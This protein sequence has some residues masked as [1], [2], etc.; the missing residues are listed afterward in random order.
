MTWYNP[1]AFVPMAVTLVTCLVYLAIIIPLLIVHETVPSAPENPTIYRGL[2]LTEAWLDLA[3]LSNGY[4][5]YNSHRNDEVRNWLLRRVEA[6]LDSNGVNYETGPD[7]SGIKAEPSHTKE[8]LHGSEYEASVFELGLGAQSA[9]SD[10]LRSRSTKPAAVVFNDLASNYTTSALTSIGVTGRRLGISTYFEGNNI[11]VYIRGTEDEEED[12]WK[13]LPPYTHRLH[14]K[15][16]VMVNAHFDSVSTGYG[17]TDDGMGVVTAL[18]LIKYYTTEGNTP[19]RGV[20]VLLNNGEED[21]LYGAKAFLSHPMATFVHTFLNLEGAGAGGR[22]MLFRSTDTEVTRAYGSAKHPLGTVVSAD[23]FALGFIR[24]ETD[25]VVFRAEGY[26]GLDV[27]F[28]EPRARYHTEQDDAKH[29]SRDSLW[30]MLSASVATMDYLTSHTEEFVGPRRDNLPGK[31]KNGRG[32]DG[33]WFDLFGMVMAVFGLRKLFAWSLTILIASPLILMLVSYLLIRQDKYYL[34]SGAVK[35]EGRETEVVSLKGWRGAFRFP[36][37]LIISGALTLG[38]AFLLKKIN[39]LIVYSSPYAVWSMSLTLFFCVFWFLMA[40]CNFVRP[41]ALHRVYALIWMFI[42]GWVLLLGATIFEDR[43]KVSSAYIFLFYQGAISLATLIGLLELFALP[44]KSTL[45]EAVRDAHE[46]REGL[47]ALPH[48]GSI[49]TGDAQDESNDADADADADEEPNETTPL[50]GGNDNQSTIGATFARGYRQII[51]EQVDGVDGADD[52]D[53]ADDKAIAFGDEQKWSANM[54]SWTWLLQFLLLG[55]S[56]III[57]GQVGLLIV[58]ALTQTGSDGSP[59]LLPYLLISVFSILLILPTTPFLHRITAHVPTFFLLIFISTLVYNLLAFPFSSNNRYKAYFQQTVDLESGI[60]Q[61]TL[62]G[63][64]EYVRLMIDEIPSAAG[65]EISCKSK[66]N[67]RQGL[68]YCSWH[69]IAPK[70]VDNVKNGIPPEKGYQ[71]WMNFNVTRAKGS[72]KATFHISG[73]DTKACIL[74]F[75]DPFTAFEVHGAA[76]SDGKWNDVPESGSDQIKLWHRD[77]DREWVVDVEW[78]V[79]EG[80]QEGEEGRS[81]RVVCFWSDH[82]E[83]GTIP[84]LDEVQRFMPAWAAVTKLMDGLVEGSKAFIV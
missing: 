5:P 60:N 10:E 79:S 36:I 13:P 18:Q 58:A 70:V 84:A 26:R 32:T 37:V 31:V 77:W 68:S 47:E 76:K 50:V 72:N 63:I 20:I 71:D 55:P 81:G 54:P 19:K 3:E 73:I 8:E 14:G 16:G 56:I 28:W 29:A 33:V 52:T 49:V 7:E 27:A 40:G 24:S 74:R 34:F 48:S 42:I 9:D 75:D 44:K 21:G 43:F 57:I 64:E 61:V 17:A 59:L 39:P 15:G 53:A 82:N 12:W 11:I 65:Q 2:N 78:P 38:A 80:K 6:I 46:T 22:A 23:G 51:P 30:H 25:Y 62:A 45:V 69:G 35:I 1:F 66:D 41:S 67:I 4:H 83:L